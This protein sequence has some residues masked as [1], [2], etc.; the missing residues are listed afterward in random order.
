MST[1]KRPEIESLQHDAARAAA[2]ALT[3]L[4]HAYYR[5]ANHKEAVKR[6]REAIAVLKDLVAP[7]AHGEH[8]ARDAFV[9]SPR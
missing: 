2:F 1:S 3:N 6:Y 8:R 9:V 5:T 7:A 4:G